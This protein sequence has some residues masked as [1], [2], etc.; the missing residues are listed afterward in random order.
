VGR[1]FKEAENIIKNYDLS[2]DFKS[3]LIDLVKKIE[4]EHE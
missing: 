4:Q 3:G 1:S 2:L